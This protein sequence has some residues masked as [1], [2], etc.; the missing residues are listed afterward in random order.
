MR[1]LFS[2]PARIDHARVDEAIREAEKTTSGEIRVVVAR[3]RTGNPVAAA[4]RHFDKLGLARAGHRH[5]V[6]IL[7]SPRSRNFA[8]VGDKGV[9]E[10][11]GES[12][13]TELAAAMGG[14]FRRG[15]FTEGV[16]HGVGRAGALLAEHFPPS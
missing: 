4:Q 14:Y 3:H 2:N 1:W 7:V 10:R 12:F 8:V 9:H 5:A 13:W 15:E 11:C 6:L 16:V